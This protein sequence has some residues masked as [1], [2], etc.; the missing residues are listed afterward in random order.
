MRFVINGEPQ[1]DD[2][3]VF[4][5]VAGVRGDAVQLTADDLVSLRELLDE[6]D[7]AWRTQELFADLLSRFVPATSTTKPEASS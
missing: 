1:H 2:V 7:G 5:S 6:P 3:G 4:A